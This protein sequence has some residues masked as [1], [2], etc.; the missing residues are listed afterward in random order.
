MPKRILLIDD[1]DQIREALC[2]GLESQGYE[3]SQAARL[4]TGIRVFSTEP[5][6]AAIVDYSLPDGT[7]LDLI[8]RLKALDATV[9]IL[10]LTGHGTIDLAVKA[11]KLGAEYFITKPLQL[12]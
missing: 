6:D 2:E 11:M 3:V 8:P 10:V 4:E 9:P 5:C 1:D 12:T 7:A